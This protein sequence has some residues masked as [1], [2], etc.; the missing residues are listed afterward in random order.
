MVG[1]T[2]RL[3]TAKLTRPHQEG[4]AFLLA[5]GITRTSLCYFPGAR[6]LVKPLQ[7]VSSL[8]QLVKT[9]RAAPQRRGV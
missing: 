9:K 3:A 4:G 5:Q 7:Q 8:G 6:V 2:L 1:A